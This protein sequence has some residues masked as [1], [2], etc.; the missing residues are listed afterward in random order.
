MLQARPQDPTFVPD[1]MA[2]RRSQLSAFMRYC[3]TETRHS[4]GDYSGFEQFSYKEFRTFWRLFLRWCKLDIEGEIEPVCA[5][6]SCEG[7]SFFPRLRLNFVENLLRQENESDDLPAVTTC[8]GDRPR[9]RLTRGELRDRVRRVA[10]ALRDMG[11]AEGDR[12]VAIARN[13]SEAIVAALATAAVGATFSSCAPDMGVFSILSRF[14]PIQP[15]LLMGHF[16]SEPWDIGA[17][18]A[19]RLAEV[20]AGLPSLKAIVALDDGATPN[21][22]ACPIHRLAELMKRDLATDDGSWTRF[23]FDHPLFILF[24]SGTTGQPKCILH[25]AGGT[26]LEHLKEH[27]LH[28]DLRQGDRLLFHTSCGWMMWNWQLS[29]LASGVELVLYDGPIT[30]PETLWELVASQRVTVFGTSPAYL[31][32]CEQSGYQPARACELASLRSVLSTGSIL[33]E[34]QYDWVRDCVKRD[35]LLQSIS[36]GTDILGC[37]VLGNPILPVHRGEAQCRSLGLDVRALPPADAPLARIGELICA[38]PFPSRPIGFF[39]D[40]DGRRFHEAYFSQNPGVWTHGDLIE[41]TPQGGARLHGR[42]DGILNIRGIR[43]GPAEIYRILQGIVEVAEAMALEQYAEDEPGGTRL[44]LLVVLRGGIAL[45][46]SLEARIR[47]E[48]ARRGSMVFV[49]ARIAQVEELPVTHSGK[50]SEAAARDAVNGRP[51]R[52][53]DALRNPDSLDAIARNPTLSAAAPAVR[54]KPRDNTNTNMRLDRQALDPRDELERELQHIFERLLGASPIGRHESFF[55]LGGSSLSLLRLLSEIRARTRFHLPFYRLFHAPT[56]A[57]IAETLRGL[58]CALEARP[59]GATVDGAV[60]QRP[61]RVPGEP[62]ASRL[63]PD[64]RPA[65]ATDIERLCVFLHRG[66]GK[67]IAAAWRPL[68]EYKWLDEKPNL[69]F[70][71]TTGA[72]IR[73]FIGTVYARRL[74]QGKTAL[75]CNLSSFYVHPDYRGWSFALFEHTLRDETVCYTSFT[76][77]PTVTRMCEALGFSYIDRNK[78]ILPPVLNAITLRGPGPQIISDPEQVRAL[79]DGEQRQ[80]FDD[81]APYDCLQLV[82]QS[83]SERAHLVAKRRKIGRFPVSDLLYCSAPSL[84]A[85]HL[86]RVKLAIIWRQRSVALTAEA[87][88]FGALRPLGGVI[89]QPMLFRSSVLQAHELDKLYSELVLLPI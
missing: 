75:V 7:A 23:A 25:G 24:S 18:V 72:E 76:P 14:A 38:N 51:A 37:F 4:Y 21:G 81:H 70:M 53:R 65:R 63:P 40:Q 89:S 47:S 73:G 87:G 31:Q 35:L 39:G 64:I 15:V 11:V 79:L 56:I 71:L 77:S 29:A 84:V 20:A 50:R 83:G 32:L 69:G 78:I 44:V 45:D 27:R 34:P 80:I 26:L 74:I 82:L 1:A 5:G 52:N 2:M 8:H 86:E 28:C 12:V 61:T 55:D 6:D 42:S 43:V 68:F 46:R 88:L 49:P 16:R 54:S 10:A 41:F 3:E 60:A 58:G 30:G 59:G 66:F 85:R 36:G 19:A 62:R 67:R 13:G 57:G 22:V 17:P 48:L 33:Y 9:E